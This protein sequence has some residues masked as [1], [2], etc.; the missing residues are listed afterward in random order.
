MA[1][2]LWIF[3]G[4]MAVA[5]VTTV[6]AVRRAEEGYEDETGFHPMKSAAPVAAGRS[7]SASIRAPEET[8]ES[9]RGAAAPGPAEAGL[10]S[11]LLGTG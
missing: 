11:G 10:P 4:V 2:L 3:L 7:A 5:A 9:R 8:V 1:L 6:V